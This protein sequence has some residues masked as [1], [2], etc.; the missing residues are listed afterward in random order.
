MVNRYLTVSD[1]AY[2]ELCQVKNELI[3]KYKERNRE[4][5]TS[6]LQGMDFSSFFGWL[7]F[8]GIKDLEENG[9]YSDREF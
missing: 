9:L 3:E 7:L 2:E 6:K 8:K 5:M 1:E 4:G